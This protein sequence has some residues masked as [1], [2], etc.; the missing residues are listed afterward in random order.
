MVPFGNMTTPTQE[1]ELDI[2]RSQRLKDV[3]YKLG[4]QKYGRLPA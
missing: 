3:W 1:K 4:V 2:R